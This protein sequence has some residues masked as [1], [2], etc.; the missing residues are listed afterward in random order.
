[1]IFIHFLVKIGA[2]TTENVMKNVIMK[3][4]CNTVTHLQDTSTY[5]NLNQ[6]LQP[7]EFQVQTYKFT[8][9]KK[10]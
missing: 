7:T 9:L 3:F 2:Y 4:Q 1:M 6:K 10:T 8:I 5:K